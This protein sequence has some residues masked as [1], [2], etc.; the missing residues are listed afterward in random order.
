MD[1]IGTGLMVTL[2]IDWQEALSALAPQFT[3][4]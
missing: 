4:R 2:T 1:Y 3:I